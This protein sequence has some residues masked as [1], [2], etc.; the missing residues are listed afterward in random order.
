MNEWLIGLVI[1]IGIVM[2]GFT[3]YLL[4][5]WVKEDKWAKW[6]IL[7]MIGL[8]IFSCYLFWFLDQWWVVFVWVFGYAFFVLRMWNWPI[9]IKEKLVER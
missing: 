2:L 4:Y 8:L 9:I 6:I 3:V 1:S 7:I 5:C